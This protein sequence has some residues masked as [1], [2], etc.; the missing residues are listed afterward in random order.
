[1]IS[2]T[3]KD[4]VLE[5]GST[6]SRTRLI[7]A[8]ALMGAFFTKYRV[9]LIV[10]FALTYPFAAVLI[11]DAMWRQVD[12][13]FENLARSYSLNYMMLFLI[14][15]VPGL[16]AFLWLPIRPIS[17]KLLS[18]CGISVA[19]LLIMIPLAFAFR[20]ISY[21]FFNQSCAPL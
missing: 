9:R 13:F 6:K 4:K 11:Q 16:L 19:Y 12:P 18:L 21:C 2:D 1:M 15:I 7:V 3:E 5:K 14:R 10:A 17:R 20:F 8:F